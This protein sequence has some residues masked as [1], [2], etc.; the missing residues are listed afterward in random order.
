MEEKY[1]VTRQLL[2]AFCDAPP[3]GVILQTHSDKI[4]EDC[5]RIGA[6]AQR[7]D[8]RVHLSIEGDG[9]RLP[10]LPP[11]PCSIEDRLRLIED[12]SQADIPVVA[13]LAPLYPLKDPHRF[14]SRLVSVGTRAAVIDHF[15]EGDGTSNGSRTLKT[16][17][18]EAMI[19][20]DPTSI[21][22]SYRDRIV[23]IARKYL[24][25]GVSRDGFA[26]KYFFEK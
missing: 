2:K 14:F 22:L 17:L 24:P 26:G 4:R 10:G 23:N 19:K 15:I 3:D 11:P 6:L 8:L 13:C 25:T 12:F 21:E 18:L 7:C 1:R 20:A 9:D 16:P 5:E